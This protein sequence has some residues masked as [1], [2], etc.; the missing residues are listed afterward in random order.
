MFKLKHLF[1]A[2]PLTASLVGCGPE[3]LQDEQSVQGLEPQSELGIIEEELPYS[4]GDNWTAPAPASPLGST[5][6]RVCFLTRIQGRF[7]SAADSVHVFTA[8]GSWYVGGSGGTSARAGCARLPAGDTFG[9]EYT[10][11]A[12]DRLPKNLGTT[13]GRVCF[14]SR[15]GGAFNSTADWVYVYPNGGSWYLFGDSQSGTGYARARC[16]SVPASGGSKGWNQT[17]GYPTHLGT[18]SGRS[19]ALSYMTGQFDS[20]N[21]SLSIYSDTGSWYLRGTSAHWGVG[22]RAQCF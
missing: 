9:G 11:N 20:M 18:T 22:G 6:G 19:C 3:D 5:T 13:T 16:V 12:G 4:H 1:V 2:L 21:E 10:W 8:G 15:V 7:D 17:Q 14:L